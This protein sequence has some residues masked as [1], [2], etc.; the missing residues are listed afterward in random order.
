PRDPG[1]VAGRA[2]VAGARGVRD[3]GAGVLVK[4]VGGDEPRD[5]GVADGEGDGRGGRGVAGGVLR[6]R[7]P[8]VGAVGDRGGVPGE[9]GG[10]RGQRGAVTRPVQQELDAGDRDVVGG[11]RGHRHA[12]PPHRGPGRGGG[13][14]HRG[15]GRIRGGRAA[16]LVRSQ[17][18][19]A[20]RVL[21]G[22]E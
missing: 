6:D 16:G 18:D 13:D 8:G 7:R 19:V 14:R 21:G 3:R 4:A 15:R 9:R 10:G 1:R 22:D 12:G 2:G 20:G 17:A 5:G 11:G